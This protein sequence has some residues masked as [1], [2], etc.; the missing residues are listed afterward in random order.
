MMQALLCGA[1]RRDGEGVALRHNVVSCTILSAAGDM[2]SIFDEAVSLH[3]AIDFSGREMTTFL[4]VQM[5]CV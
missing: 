1:N 5:S 4:D 2:Q 3:N